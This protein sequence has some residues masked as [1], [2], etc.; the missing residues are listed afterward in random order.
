MHLSTNTP[1]NFTVFA[2]GYNDTPDATSL[3]GDPGTPVT[4]PATVPTMGEWGLITLTLLL[5]SYCTLAV[6]SMR[7]AGGRA[8]SMV[9]GTNRP[10]F[11]WEIYKKTLFATG[12]LA[13]LA[14]ILSIVFTGTITTVDIIGTMVAGP[15]FAYLMHLLILFEKNK[16]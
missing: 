10:S 2:Y 16:K 4:P 11:Q 14:G 5:L 15:I 8:I 13:M 9:T 1:V 6:Q 7:T 3:A 12:L